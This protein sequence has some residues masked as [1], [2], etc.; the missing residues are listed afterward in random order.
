VVHPP[1]GATPAAVDAYLA[2]VTGGYMQALS[3]A[4]YGVGTGTASKGAIDATP[5]NT[6]ATITDASIRSRIQADVT[7]GLLQNPDANRLY[8]VY[9][10]PNVAVNLGS[11]QGTTQQGILGYHGAFGGADAHGNAVTLRYAVVA[12]PGGGVGSSTLPEATTALDQLTAVTSHELAEAVTDPDVNYS[13]LGWYDPQRGEIGDITESN[14]SAYVRLDGYLVQE[15]ANR[16]DQLL[17]ITTTSPTPPPTP[18][19]VS[20]TTTIKAGPVHYHWFGPATETLTVIITPAS[21]TVAPTGTVEL[22]YN[23]TVLGTAQVQVVNGVA[24]AIFTIDYY[25]NGSYTFTAQ[26]LG[27]G[28]FQGSTSNPVTVN[29]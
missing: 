17:T 19:T 10:Q 20:T 6:N 11:G 14:P 12:Y 13:T 28:Q 5:Y 18:G 3:S 27:S 24:E 21:G 29:V 25:A 2:D 4:G 26:Y 9:V 7:S 16:N 1:S 15:V 23:G 8:I 22:I